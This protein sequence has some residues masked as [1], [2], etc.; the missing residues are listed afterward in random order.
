MEG[1]GLGEQSLIVRP[2]TMLMLYSYRKGTLHDNTYIIRTFCADSLVYFTFI[3]INN[4]YYVDPHE[5]PDGW[6]HT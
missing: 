5:F 4:Y 1:G 2:V 6:P 3:I